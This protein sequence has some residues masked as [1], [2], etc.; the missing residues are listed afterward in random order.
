MALINIG[1]FQIRVIDEPE[2]V[3][4]RPIGASEEQVGR[5][6]LALLTG[7][8]EIQLELGLTE[9]KDFDGEVKTLDHGTAPLP[10]S[11]LTHGCRMTIFR[12]KDFNWSEL[13]YAKVDENL[14]S[15]LSMAELNSLSQLLG[16]SLTN[17]LM[18]Q[19][20]ISVG[21]RGEVLG[22]TNNRRNQLCVTY[23]KDN[24]ILPFVAYVLTRPL[25]LFK[26]M[27]INR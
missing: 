27:T 24:Q 3:L 17:I 8:E 13:R 23:P 7:P 21:T 25:A 5:R 2:K 10:Y 20:A 11:R 1:A 18:E 22:E 19:G 15:N 26:Q 12:E 6:F 16:I 14:W 4:D 9:F